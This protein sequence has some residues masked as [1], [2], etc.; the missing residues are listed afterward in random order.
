MRVTPRV[1]LWSACLWLL[2][3][4]AGDSVYGDQV[5]L[6][7]SAR[8]V[9]SETCLRRAACRPSGPLGQQ[10]VYLGDSPAFPGASEVAFA[11]L[12]A[13]TE[14]TILETEMVTAVE[15]GTEQP[16]EIRFYRVDD[17]ESEATGWVPGFCLEQRP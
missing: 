12:Q 4:C 14:V 7:G 2:V 15:Q 9:C 5:A 16:L 11:G 3:A 8:L 6:D 1:A 13:G 10:T 17:P